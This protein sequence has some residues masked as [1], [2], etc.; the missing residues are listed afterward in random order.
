[1]PPP[2]QRTLTLVLAG[3]RGSRLQELTQWRAKPAVPFGGNYRIIDFTLSNCVNSGLRRIGVLTQYKA[4]DLIHHVRRAWG[5]LRPELDE[6]VELL[7][8]QQRTVDES[9]YKGTAD[10][11]YQNLDIVR[12]HR[13]ALIL[14]LA[15]DHIYKMDYAKLLAWHVERAAD[16]TVGCIEVP[17]HA[18]R[19]FG[20][21][22]IDRDHRVI[23]FLEKPELPPC[24]PAS[25]D[26]ALAS[27]GIYVFNAEF[28]YG[29]LDRDAG[30]QRSRHDFG[31]D[32]LPDLVPRHRVFAHPFRQACVGSAAEPY[33]RDVGTLDAYW[34]ANLDLTAP[35]PALDLY[36]PG[37]P[38]G[39]DRRPR[40]PAKFVC[41]PDGRGG[42]AVDSLVADGC[43][44]SGATVRRSVLSA[45]VTVE[46]GAVVEES[47]L[48]PNSVVGRGC[49]LHRVI[50][51]EGC[52]V[53]AG[54]AVGDAPRHDTL[55]LPRSSAGVTL[56]T[57]DI[58]DRL[59][60]PAPAIAV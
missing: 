37:W 11:V 44:V 48:L 28:L 2:S 6:F 17:L 7:P 10:A 29:L 55:P 14:V 31:G 46:P 59:D 8:A 57:A 26:R 12:R 49:R 34:A 24:M 21:M 45:D 35:V 43:V 4:H 3:G 40:P 13:P 38:I 33:W 18:A 16:V 50:L 5:F 42:T 32:L 41:G 25:P 51:D 22:D 52:R 36:D 23:G 9:W 20:V 58:L 39:T 30:R 1:L 60:C 27:M 15:G 47:V 19:A 54:L 53:P 56:L